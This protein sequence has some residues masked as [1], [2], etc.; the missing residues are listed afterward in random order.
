VSDAV[1]QWFDATQTSGADATS[2]LT[3]Q[4]TPLLRP[5]ASAG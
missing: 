1:S 2:T 4:T 3:S 5:A